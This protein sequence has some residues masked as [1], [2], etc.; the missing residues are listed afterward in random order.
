MRSLSINCCAICASIILGLVIAVSVYANEPIRKITEF[1]IYTDE[2]ELVKK[3]KSI[4][5][6]EVTRFGFCFEA[7]VNFFDDD[8]YMLIQ[9]LEHP[10]IKDEGGWPNK[11]YNVPRMFKVKNGIAS[12][13]AD[14]KARNQAEMLAGDWIFSITDGGEELIRIKFVVE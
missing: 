4:P 13:C 14:F 10:P 11:G 12:G 8:A 2:H 5:A 7:F 3:T 6:G 1:G 9:S